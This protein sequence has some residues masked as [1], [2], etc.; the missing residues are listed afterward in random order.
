M[1]KAFSSDLAVRLNF[2][3]TAD[4]FLR[5]RSEALCDNGIEP[6]FALLADCQTILV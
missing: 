6:A 5:C 2:G 4:E 1:R 3:S